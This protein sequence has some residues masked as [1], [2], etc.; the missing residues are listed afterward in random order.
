MN[1]ANSMLTLSTARSVLPPAVKTVDRWLA[2]VNAPRSRSRGLDYGDLTGM[3]FSE[4]GIDPNAMNRSERVR[5]LVSEDAMFRDALDM[6]QADLASRAASLLSDAVNASGGFSKCGLVMY[7][8]TAVDENFYQSTA[9][10]IASELELSKAPHFSVAQLQGAS[11]FQALDIG[12]AFLSTDEKMD[13]ALFI[14]SEKWPI[15]YPRVMGLPAVF[16]DGAVAM[17]FVRAGSKPGLRLVSST[18]KCF[19][20]FGAVHAAHGTMNLSAICHAVNETVGSFMQACGVEAN[21]IASLLTSCGCPTLDRSIR[22]S[23]GVPER[24]LNAVSDDI[25]YLSA[26]DIPYKRSEALTL[27][28]NGTLAEG[29][30]ILAIGV[31][32]GGSVGAALFKAEGVNGE[33]NG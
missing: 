18:V 24:T 2:E 9:C 26:A 15:P 25:G 10:R 33:A 21:D 16:S 5:A 14:A 1:A 32:L 29:S 20:D 6:S 27:V 13:S 12:D 23:L 28:T 8:H 19:D 3:V 17:Q 4:C 31:G 30:L 22:E 7:S 11:F